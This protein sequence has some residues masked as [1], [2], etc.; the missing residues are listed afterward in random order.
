MSRTSFYNRSTNTLSIDGVTVKGIAEGN[1][2]R[3]IEEADG[4]VT[5]KGL[6]RALTS[7]NNDRRRRLEVDLLPTSPYRKVVIGLKRRQ[8]EG[9]GRILKG[10]IRSGVNEVFKMEGMAVVRT[11]DLGTG[12]VTPT[13]MTMIFTVEKAVGDET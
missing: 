9:T 10:S 5:T 2:I 3:L 1:A 4:A 8:D 11:G 13:N 7:I 6:D 12:D